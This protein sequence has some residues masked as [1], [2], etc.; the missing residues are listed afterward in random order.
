MP[1]SKGKHQ[2][3]AS[4]LTPSKPCPWIFHD[5]ELDKKTDLELAGPLKSKHKPEIILREAE[6]TAQTPE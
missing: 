5:Q 1:G 4:P 3:Q 6:K 2:K